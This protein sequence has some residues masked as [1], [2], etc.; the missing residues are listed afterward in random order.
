MIIYKYNFINSCSHAR[1]RE[2]HN[3]I[4]HNFLPITLTLKA[5][6]KID[7]HW[8]WLVVAHVN[9]NPFIVFSTS[10]MVALALVHVELV[11]MS[12][13]KL[14]HWSWIFEPSFPVRLQLPIAC[15][16]KPGLLHMT[17]LSGSA[18]LKVTSFP[19]KRQTVISG[20]ELKSEVLSLHKSVE[21]C[22]S[23]GN[24]QRQKGILYYLPEMWNHTKALQLNIILCFI[25]TSYRQGM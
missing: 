3:E 19:G 10:K 2:Q 6:E 24:D 21:T 4:N 5:V 13:V 9:S 17:R 15:I 7:R 20:V 18:Q 14:I 8:A 23:S 12:R 25:K 22:I 1:K 16:S 11:F